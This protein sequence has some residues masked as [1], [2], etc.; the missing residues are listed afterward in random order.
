MSVKNCRECEAWHYKPGDRYCGLCGTPLFERRRL[1]MEVGEDDAHYSLPLHNESYEPGAYLLAPP[2][3]VQFELPTQPTPEG[4][5]V[6]AAELKPNEQRNVGFR[7]VSAKLGGRRSVTDEYVRVLRD[8]RLEREVL[9][10]LY[11]KPRELQVEDASFYLADQEK[12]LT[13]VSKDAAFAVERA[14]FECEEEGLKIELARPGVVLEMGRSAL[15]VKVSAVRTGAYEVDFCLTA[16]VADGGFELRGQFKV[17]VKHHPAI[18]FDEAWLTA[19][20]RLSLPFDA[21]PDERDKLVLRVR[22]AGEEVLEIERAILSPRSEEVTWLGNPGP[23][24]IEPG[25]TGKIELSYRLKPTATGNIYSDL[26][27]DS[28][29]PTRP[30]FEIVFNVNEEAFNQFLAIDYGTSTSSA[31]FCVNRSESVV[32]EQKSTKVSSDVV[33]LSDLPDG[34]D[35]AYD[36]AI[37]REAEG[38]GPEGW[39]RLATA[40]KVR[41]GSPEPFQIYLPDTREIAPEQVVRMAL[42]EL[43]RYARAG[44]G[45]RPK[46]VIFTT[47][48][49]FTLKQKRILGEIF[50]GVLKEKG[51]SPLT[52]VDTDE[53]FAAGFYFLYEGIRNDPELCTR[54]DYTLMVID[55]GGGTTDVTLFRVSQAPGTT[56]KLPVVQGLEVLGA[57]GDPELGGHALTSLIA[58][59]IARAARLDERDSRPLMETAEKVKYVISEHAKYARGR[60]G[61]DKRLLLPDRGLLARALHSLESGTVG[62]VSEEQPLTKPELERR[63]NQLQANGRLKVQLPA[64][65]GAAA[66]REVEL[67]LRQIAEKLQGRVSGFN[68]EMRQLLNRKGMEQVDKILF[69]GQSSLLPMVPEVFSALGR[70]WD[71]VRGADGEPILKEAVSLGAARYGT[72]G[73]ETDA[74]GADRF[75]RILGTPRAGE[76]QELLPWGTPVPYE[77]EVRFSRNNVVEDE[78]GAAIEFTLCEN[79]TLIPG[80]SRLADYETFRVDI[81]ASRERHFE[82]KLRLTEE[83]EIEM[84]CKLGGTWHRMQPAGG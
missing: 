33:F 78:T 48:T 55:I 50:R 17:V 31:A 36:Y 22:N 7:V 70:S 69:Y 47:P 14:A 10:E 39:R 43:V 5:E 53:A 25:D 32:L 9:I 42:L 21:K 59:D 35:P 63:R 2:P 26:R 18:T 73:Y 51:L 4:I 23:L 65:L 12:D 68:R 72:W 54:P 76:F 44:L 34:A 20:G 45:K 1:L 19:Q 83:G 13:V 41:L 75:W 38:L 57:W 77:A 8:G 37:G 46:K 79:L 67:D 84:H 64:A 49:R 60:T 16:S 71:Y 74:V 58:A 81:G 52:V 24:T 61:I 40:A 30:S 6:Y 27:F 82:G 66:L 3:W 15:P 28:N 56:E 80:E 62:R 29:D 11:P